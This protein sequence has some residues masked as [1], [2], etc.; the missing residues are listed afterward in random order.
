[1]KVAILGTGKMGGAMARRLHAQGFELRLWNRTRKRA[2]QLGVGEVFDTP[3]EA[4]RDAE[5]VISM[6]T[7]PAAVRDAYLGPHGALE[8]EGSRIYID[9]STVDPKTHQALARVVEQ[10]G[11]SFIEAPVVGSIPAVEAGKL[12]IMVGGE[13]ATFE[14][15]RVVLQVLGD[16]RYIGPLGSAARLKLVA[17]SMLGIISAAAGELYNAGLRAGLDRERVWEVLTRLAPY[18]DARR[19]GYLEG[20]Y[21]PVMFR[22]ADMVKDL[23]LALEVYQEV[24]IDTPLSQATRELFERAARDH[25]EEDLAAIAELWR[26]PAAA[27]PADR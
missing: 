21:D 7:D 15:L 4:T 14:R 18:L 9:S 20:R 24:G 6:L 8:A 22:L 2:E 27:A 17:N 13:R 1:M 16:A 10:R 5:V 3:A 19:A 12:L 11:S 25:G 26:Q 23:D